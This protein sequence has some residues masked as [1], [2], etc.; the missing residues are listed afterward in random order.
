MPLFDGKPDAIGDEPF[1]AVC[2]GHLHISLL[3]DGPCHDAL[4][5]G[6]AIPQKRLS[7]RARE[8]GESDT[9]PVHVVPKVFP[10]DMGGEPDVEFGERGEVAL[11]RCDEEGVPETEN[12]TRCER[13]LVVRIGTDDVVHEGE[14]LVRVGK[15]LDI[16][17]PVRVE[18]QL[19][20]CQKAVG[21]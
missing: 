14:D 1:D 18:S 8:H 11:G 21:K 16:D 2:P 13:G 20:L 3:V 19:R 7:I 15:D 9:E 10:G 12:E 6:L 17:L 5:R 4:A